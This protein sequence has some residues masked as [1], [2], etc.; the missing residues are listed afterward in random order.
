MP[1]TKSAWKRMR[2]S[3]VARLANRAARSTISK[4]KK[5][6]VA[7]AAGGDVQKKAQTLRAFFSVVDKAAKKGVITSNTASR[8]KSRAAKLVQK[9]SGHQASTT[10]ST[11]L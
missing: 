3:E 5:A 9:G 11:I 6:V 1:H 7:A 10:A 2:T 8:K 4:A